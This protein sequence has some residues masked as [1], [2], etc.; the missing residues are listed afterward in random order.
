MKIFAS[1][2][3][4][5]ASKPQIANFKQVAVLAKSAK[6]PEISVKFRTQTPFSRFSP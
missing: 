4:K 2:A 5:A 1:T 3:E 6:E